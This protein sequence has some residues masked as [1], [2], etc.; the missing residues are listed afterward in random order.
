MLAKVLTSPLVQWKLKRQDNDLSVIN[1]DVSL[2]IIRFNF[3][4]GYCTRYCIRRDVFLCLSDIRRIVLSVALK[5][6]TTPHD[7]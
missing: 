3:T 6:N 5:V 2:E 7:H 4:N 1:T